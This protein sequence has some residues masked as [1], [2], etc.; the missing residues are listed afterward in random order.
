MD[1][2]M[3]RKDHFGPNPDC[4][5]VLRAPAQH[6]LN[7]PGVSEAPPVEKALGSW[8]WEDRNIRRSCGSV[9]SG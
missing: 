5:E 3:D 9:Q 7:A 1:R 2:S 8:A 6:A 4:G